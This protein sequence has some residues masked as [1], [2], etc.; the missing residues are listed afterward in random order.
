MKKPLKHPTILIRQKN[1][2]NRTHTRT[3]PQKRTERMKLRERE[4]SE[5]E[6]KRHIV[7][8]IKKMRI[9]LWFAE[10]K[11]MSMLLKQYP[12]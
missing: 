5:E 9:N 8:V 11:V 6:R 3:R 1:G 7:V 4:V 12:T 10:T 2:R